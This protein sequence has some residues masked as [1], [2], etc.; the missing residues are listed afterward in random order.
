MKSKEIQFTY[1]MTVTT[2]REDFLS[3]SK[4]K[5]L[6]ISKLRLQ[7]ENDSQNVYVSQTDADTDIVKVA[8]K[9]LFFEFNY[10][11]PIIFS[12]IQECYC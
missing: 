10:I 2:K 11:K 9:V 1:D 4:N 7:L 5:A 8:L 12:G 3:N 6:L